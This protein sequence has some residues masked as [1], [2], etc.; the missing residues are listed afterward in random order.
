MDLLGEGRERL[1]V[2]FL[3]VS[4]ARDVTVVD[5]EEE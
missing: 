4:D 3:G 5:E 2:A 1:G